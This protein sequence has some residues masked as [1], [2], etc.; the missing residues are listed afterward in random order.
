MTRTVYIVQRVEWGYDDNWF[1]PEGDTPI[2]AF[3]SREGAEA[4]RR[5]REAI[6]RRE[7]KEPSDEYGWK[8]NLTWNFGPLGEISSLTEAEL[9]DRVRGLGLPE[10]TMDDEEAWWETIW[11]TMTP[12][13]EDAFWQLFDRLQFF[14]VVEVELD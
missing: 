11:D 9:N 2:K 13:Q 4:H 5:E 3:R 6:Q 12:E 7:I 10:M 14:T 1:Y 8:R